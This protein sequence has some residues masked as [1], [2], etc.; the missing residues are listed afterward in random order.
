MSNCPFVLEQRC[1]RTEIAS[2]LAMCTNCRPLQ[3]F[4]GSIPMKVCYP[5]FRKMMEVTIGPNE[6]KELTSRFLKK[7][8][9]Q[10]SA[11]ILVSKL[12]EQLED[13]DKLYS[14]AAEQMVTDITKLVCGKEL[15]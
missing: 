13:D 10:S 15:E 8:M 2:N 9:T 7:S 3:N 4:V 12:V 6:T 14:D 1:G 11:K 5:V